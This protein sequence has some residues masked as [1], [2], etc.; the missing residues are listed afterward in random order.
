MLK[1]VYE[2][3]PATLPIPYEPGWNL[4]FAGSI[5]ISIE[6]YFKLIVEF[7]KM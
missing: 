1:G 6:W 7:I 3:I 5:R 4:W 2:L